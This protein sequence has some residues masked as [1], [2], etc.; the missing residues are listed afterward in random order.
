M[1]LDATTLTTPTGSLAVLATDGV[2]VAAGFGTV[3]QMAERVGD[4]VAVTQ[5]SDL[6]SISR[7]LAAYFVGDLAAMDDIP[8][9]QPGGDFFQAA[10]K[11]MR[12][13]P[14]GETITYTELAERVGR[15]RAVRAA[16]SACARNRIAPFIPCHR[17]LRADGQVG[18]YYY[19]LAAKRWLLDHERRHSSR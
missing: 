15:P 4:G 19:G 8:V 1:T 10:W 16:G 3:E 13:V 17:I 9:E 12:E 14:A 5:R 6:G 7:A 18:G 11:V 2:V